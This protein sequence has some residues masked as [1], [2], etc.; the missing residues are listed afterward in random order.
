[1]TVRYTSVTAAET[2]TTTPGTAKYTAP[3]VGGLEVRVRV[4]ATNV[5]GAAARTC[6]IAIDKGA[7]HAAQELLILADAFS[8]TNNTAQTLVCIARL[9]GHKTDPDTLRIWNS[10]AND[11]VFVLEIEEEVSNW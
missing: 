8:I 10:V 5:D 11:I 4:Y 1:M 9:K 3:K 6:T 7:A 2:T